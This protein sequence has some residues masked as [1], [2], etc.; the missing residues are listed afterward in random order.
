MGKAYASDLTPIT[1]QL[2]WKHQF[3]FA[4]YYAAKEKGFYSDA[5]FDVTLKEAAPGINPIEE[6]LNGN[7]QYG[8]ANAELL[9]Y[10]MT[11]RP[12]TALAVIFQHSPL[13]LLSLR[14]TGITSPQD[15]VGKKVMFP[16][17]HYGANTLGMLLKEGVDESKVNQ[18][19]LSF[20]IDDLITKKVDAMVGYITDKPFI[21]EQQNIA[22]N[23]LEPRVYG[24]DFYGDTLFTSQRRAENSFD[25]VTRFREATLRGWLYAMGHPNEMIDIILNRYQSQRTRAELK[26]EAEVSRKLIMP[27]LVEMGHMNPGRWEHIAET[28]RSLHLVSGGFDSDQFIFDPEKRLMEGNFEA[29]WKTFSFILLGGFVF[30]LVLVFFN[31]RLQKRVK[32]QTCHLEEANQFLVKQTDELIAAETKLTELNK[33]LEERVAKRTE[34]LE[35]LNKD[36]KQEIEIRHQRELS[37]LLMSHALENSKSL[38]TIVDRTGKIVYVNNSMQDFTGSLGSALIGRPLSDLEQNLPFPTVDEEKF[39]TFAK[40]QKMMELCGFD[41]GRATHWFQATISPIFSSGKLPD[42][43]VIIC[44][45]VTS[46]KQRQ[47]E[48]ERLAFY[49]ALT[50]LENRVLFKH[51]LTRMLEQAKRGATKSALLFLDLDHFKEVNDTYGHD[52]G[53]FVLKTIATRIR[54]QVRETDSVARISGDEFGVLLIDIHSN[55]D[56]VRVASYMLDE[57]IRP[58]EYE[59]NEHFVSVSIGISITPDDGVVPE[60]LIR[61]ADLAMYKAKRQGRNNY[62]FYS[63]SMHDEAQRRISLE[64]DLRD[65]IKQNQFVLEYQ[66]QVCLAN[67]QVTGV[68]ALLRWKHPETDVRFPED[69][70]EVAENSGLVVPLGEWVLEEVERTRQ[71]LV[72]EGLEHLKISIN[73]SAKQFDDERFMTMLEKV[74]ERQGGGVVDYQIELKEKVVF[75]DVNKSLNKL[76]K[77]KGLGYSILIDDFGTGFS[78]LGYLRQLPI[79]A[80]KIDK[81]FINR[82]PSDREA[83]EITLA[84]IAMAHKFNIKVIAEGVENEQQLRFLKTHGCD[85][86]QGYYFSKAVPLNDLIAPSSNIH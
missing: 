59:G 31:N 66:T 1:L 44:E 57:A 3:Q 33:H 15:L 80:I 20:N 13:V 65:S 74:A 2:K 30:V 14:E 36:L 72:R 53:D 47:D 24:V 11:G 42:H 67:D 58:I 82:V 64:N 37:L 61:N 56:A 28:F 83:I 19:P 18:I 17:G 76:Q 29:A 69:F 4:G 68:E 86:A 62:H 48:M 10:R 70:L 71:A 34:D 38:V 25:E 26:Y 46:L 81:S 51:N 43:Y 6:V 55:D 40:G 5:G 23:V 50:G 16:E 60:A 54:N 35:V 9:L 79:D 75:K 27:K 73:V 12:V 22:H 78:S 49:D 63:A 45:D 39:L 32:E 77:L 7:A 41:A 85:M 21:L 84:S 8:V 52:A